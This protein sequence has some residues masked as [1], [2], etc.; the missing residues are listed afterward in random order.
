[1]RNQVRVALLLTIV[2]VLA[3][4]A[5]GAAESG[6]V[7]SGKFTLPYD[8]QWGKAVLP[9]GEYSLAMDTMTGPLAVRDAAGRTRALFYGS[10]EHAKADQPT[11][12]LV[13]IAGTSRTV[14]ALN[15]PVW[16]AN[17]VFKAVTREERERLADLRSET[18]PVRLAS[19]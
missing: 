19:R 5:L 10:R 4:A 2:A 3:V 15:C 13:T 16:G 7:Y 8:V 18:I 12:L 11:G 9:A 17:L 14:R 6:A 1:M